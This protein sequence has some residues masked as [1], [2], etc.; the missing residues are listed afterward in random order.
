MV[1]VANRPLFDAAATSLQSYRIHV[2][3]AHRGRFIQLFLGM[4]FYQNVLPS[5]FS[6][7]HVGVDVLQS[8]LDDLYAKASRPL[9]ACVYMLFEGSYHAR[10]GLTAPG[11]K[12]PQNTWRNNFHLQKGIGCYAPAQ[13]LASQTFLD[14]P[15]RN[16]K[17]LLPSQPGSLAGGVC[18]LQPSGAQYRRE[19]HRKWL[20]VDPAGNGFSVVDLMNIDNFSPYVAPEGTRIPLLPLMVCLYYDA[21]PG[22]V[23]AERREVDTLD[24]MHDFNFSPQEAAAYFDDDPANQFNRKLLRRFKTVSFRRI[25]TPVQRRRSTQRQVRS[26]AV[27][28][29]TS[30]EVAPPAVNTGWDAQQYVANAL[31]E[32]GWEVFDVSRQQLGYDLLAKRRRQTRY[33]EVKSSLGYCGPVLTAREWQQAIA[34]QELFVLAVIENFDPTGTNRVNWIVNPAAKCDGRIAHQVQYSILRTDWL[35]ACVPLAD[36]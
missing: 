32:H 30:T 14:E 4:K 3:R 35:A 28:F 19:D 7:Q 34:H 15:R 10:T 9:H 8:L 2:G 22:L 13:D 12:V 31:R 24:F 21:L 18:R 17:Y 29:T 36:I 26:N 6:H 16:C 27:V 23:I 1:P 11:H 33:I 25:A 5:M 20:H